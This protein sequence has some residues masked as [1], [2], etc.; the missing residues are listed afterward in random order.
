MRNWNLLEKAPDNNL[1]GMSN[2]LY[3]LTDF[4]RQFARGE[5]RIQEKVVIYNN[6]FRGFSGGLVTIQ[7]CLSSKF[8]Y[9][10][11]MKPSTEALNG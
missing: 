10:E 11:L 1:N 6:E 4:G 2:G 5:V 8:S 7:D 9:S 3:R